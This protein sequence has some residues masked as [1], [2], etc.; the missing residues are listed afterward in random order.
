MAQGTGLIARTQTPPEPRELIDVRPRTNQRR[1]DDLHHLELLVVRAIVETESG[2]ARKGCP[3]IDRMGYRVLNVM[4]TNDS[5]CVLEGVISA[6][7][8]A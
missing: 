1:E 3:G 7:G 8:Q 5:V 6:V 4:K 2:S